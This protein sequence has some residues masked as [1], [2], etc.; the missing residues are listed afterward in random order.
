MNDTIGILIVGAILVLTNVA[1][2]LPIFL[3]V[4]DD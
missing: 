2:W 1:V 3:G 4:Y